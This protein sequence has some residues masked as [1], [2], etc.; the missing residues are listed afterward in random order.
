MPL[1]S[2]NK[3]P[4]Y[5]CGSHQGVLLWPLTIALPTPFWRHGHRADGTRCGTGMTNGAQ[6]LVPV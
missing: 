2:G 5:C 4:G 1:I 3:E 6:H